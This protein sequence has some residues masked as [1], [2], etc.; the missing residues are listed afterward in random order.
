M[1]DIYTYN[2]NHYENLDSLYSVKPVLSGHSKRISNIG[3]QEQ[4]SVN[5]GQKYCRMLQENILQYF[6][7]SLSYHSSLRPLFCSF[8]SGRLRQVLLYSV[9]TDFIKLIIIAAPM[10]FIRKHTVYENNTFMCTKID[11]KFAKLE[12]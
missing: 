5:I 9:G 2:S 10:T 4:L 6:R 11:R 1:Q 3:F 8:L 7:P 12:Q